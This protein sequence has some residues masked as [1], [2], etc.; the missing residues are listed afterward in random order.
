MLVRTLYFF[1]LIILAS[2]S[3]GSFA[4]AANPGSP[5]HVHCGIKTTETTHSIKEVMK[6]S[7]GKCANYGCDKM[8]RLLQ[9]SKTNFLIKDEV[10][11]CQ[12][13][14]SKTV[15]CVATID[16]V[17]GIYMRYHFNT[18]NGALSLIDKTSG[19]EAYT[20]WSNRHKLTKSGY[21]SVNTLL[22]NHNGGLQGNPRVFEIEANCYAKNIDF[23]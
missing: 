5:T 10:F 3:L 13:Y 18:Q 14:N 2:L 21:L 20:Q 15:T 12:Q 8:S 6:L 4:T 9:Y 23:Q 19:Q 16:S 11:E 22:A 7:E 1:S 17:P